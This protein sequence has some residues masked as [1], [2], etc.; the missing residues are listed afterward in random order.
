MAQ[1]FDINLDIYKEQHVITSSYAASYAEFGRVLIM[2]DELEE[3]ERLLTKSIELRKQMPKFTKL[4][5]YTPTVALSYIDLLRGH[6]KGAEARLREALGVRE[7][8]YG[9]DD[10]ESVR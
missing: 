7:E 1:S 8:A 5:L 9:F 4:Q 10:R 6:L 3:A 2:N